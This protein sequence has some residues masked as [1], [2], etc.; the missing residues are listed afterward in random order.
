MYMI[1]Y[2]VTNNYLTCIQNE[3]GSVRLFALDEAERYATQTASGSIMAL[4]KIEGL[5]IISIEEV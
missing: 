2:W 1:L 4:G 3:D 5:R